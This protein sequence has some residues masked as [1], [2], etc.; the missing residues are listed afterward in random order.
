MR[1]RVAFPI[2]LGTALLGVV[3]GCHRPP[4]A[5]VVATVNGKEIMRPE[6][7]RNY[8]ASLGDAPQKLSPQESDIRRLT[9][10]HQMIADEIHAAARRQAQPGRVR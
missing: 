2:L 8:Q 7:D 9:I 3:A 4:S 10:L 5:D 1:S 6:L